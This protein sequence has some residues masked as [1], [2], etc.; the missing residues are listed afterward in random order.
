M[1]SCYPSILERQNVK[2][3]LKVVHESTFAALTIQNEQRCPEFRN[4]TPDF[5]QIL[6]TLWKIF[7]VNMPYKHVRLNDPLSTPLKFDDERFVFNLTS[8][9]LVRCLPG[10]SWK[11]WRTSVESSRRRCGDTHTHIHTHTHTHTTLYIWMTC[12]I[13]L[14]ENF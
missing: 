14:G 7:N 4:H 13:D 6:L 3:V 2:L 12:C 8:C 5:V 10:I 11:G 1:K 9:I